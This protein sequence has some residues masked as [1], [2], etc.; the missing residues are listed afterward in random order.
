MSLGNPHAQRCTRPQQYPSTVTH[1]DGTSAAP[2]LRVWLMLAVEKGNVI[3][4]A[5][6]EMRGASSVLGANRWMSPSAA[7]LWV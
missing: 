7:L 4:G 1:G 2:L 3:G 5:K 6:W